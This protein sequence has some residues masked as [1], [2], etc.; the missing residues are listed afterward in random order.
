MAK[1]TLKAVKKSQD[2]V[3]KPRL[4]ITAEILRKICKTLRL[5]VFGP[6]ED[7]VL[8]TAFCLAFWVYKSV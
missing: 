7:L 4:S 6:Y 1:N 3:V 8:E 2:N 5:G